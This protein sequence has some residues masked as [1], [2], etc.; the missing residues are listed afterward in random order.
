MI[1]DDVV[2]RAARRLYEC[3]KERSDRCDAIISAAKGKT[4]TVGM[5]PWE[6]CWQAFYDDAHAA[7]SASGLEA[8]QAR[9]KVLEGALEPFAAGP[10]SC[11]V[12]QRASTCI[13][14]RARQA[15]KQESSDAT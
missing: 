13:S 11:G 4:V 8:L 9:V 14:C 15:L 1:T 10:C 7:L 3:E 2:E 5:E 12:M 6:E